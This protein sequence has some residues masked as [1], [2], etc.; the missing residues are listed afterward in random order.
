[1]ELLSI[2]FENYSR[3]FNS[4]NCYN[5]KSSTAG[6]GEASGAAAGGRVQKGGKTNI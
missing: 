5:V 6:G 1:V 2:H 3:I 4:F